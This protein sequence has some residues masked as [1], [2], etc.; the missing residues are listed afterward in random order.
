VGER[1]VNKGSSLSIPPS[2]KRYRS[3]PWVLMSWS[4]IPL[5]PVS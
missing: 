2:I 4:Y 1:P 3:E 5:T